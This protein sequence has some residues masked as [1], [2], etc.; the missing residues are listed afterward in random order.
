MSYEKQADYE[1]QW[2]FPPSLE[3]LV[4]A[5]HPARMVREFV[6]SQDLG[7]LGFAERKS[8]DGRPNYSANLLLKV[9]LYGYVSRTRSSR[10]L[11]RAC[12]DQMGMLWLAGMHQPDHT[13]LWR[14]WRDNREGIGGMF[15]QLLRIATSMEL[16]GMVLHAVDGTKVLSQASERRGWHRWKLEKKRERLD[17][18]IEEILKQTEQAETQ[19]QGEYRLP[20]QLQQQEKLRDT[21]QQQLKRMQEEDRDH[22]H[23][24]DPESRVMKSGLRKQFAYNAQV[25]A[26]VVT[27][28]SDNYQL[29]PMLEQVE[30]NLGKVAQDTVAD[31]GYAATTELGA[32]ERKHYSVLVDLAEPSATK[33][34]YHASRF[35]YD[36][37]RNQCICPRGEILKFD[38][39]KQRPEKAKPYQVQVYRCQSYESCAVRWQCSRSKTGRTVQIHP[40]HEALVRQRLK[41]TDAS[42]REAMKKRGRIIEPIFGWSKE[43][44][45]FRR[46]TVRGLEK[47]KTQWLLVCTAMNLRRLHKFWVSGD[48]V[49]GP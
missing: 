40:D 35:Q 19:E 24:G 31:N 41:Q 23:P 36:A 48:L 30:E 6:D 3:D 28:E 13:T 25:A 15:R 45:G 43:A 8:E 29:V 10:G 5:D 14:F 37:I 1:K 47:T 21:I 32:A 20:E 26:D 16:V 49:F 27:D 17:A 12:M 42:K 2:L 11:E 18:A 9:W 46:W 39:I 44:M 7:E 22:L 33:Q 34:P 4:P 38:S